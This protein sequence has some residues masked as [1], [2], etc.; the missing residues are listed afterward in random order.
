MAF[1]I[2]KFFTILIVLTMMSSF[3][4]G[5]ADFGVTIE[6]VVPPKKSVINPLRGTI[7]GGDEVVVK[8]RV[9]NF[10]DTPGE[11]FG[12]MKV[13]TGIY[14][15]DTIQTWYPGVDALFSLFSFQRID[16]CNI[17][18][19]N[20][21]TQKI[22]L[23]EK[24]GT[25][26]SA[27]IDF[28][29]IA[30]DVSFVTTNAFGVHAQSFR[31]CWNEGLG[32]TGQSDYSVFPVKLFTGLSLGDDQTC[33]DGIR[34]QDETGTDCGGVCTSKD[35]QQRFCGRADDCRSDLDC[36]QSTYY[37][38][39]SLIPALS[40]STLIGKCARL[41]VQEPEGNGTGIVVTCGDELCDPFQE[42]WKTCPTD[43]EEPVFPPDFCF[44]NETCID[45]EEITKSNSITIESIIRADPD[46]LAESVC[47]STKRD[48]EDDATCTSLFQLQENNFISESDAKAVAKETQ[49]GLERLADRLGTTGVKVGA[50]SAIPLGVAGCI[51]LA[52]SLSATGVFT[53]PVCLQGLGLGAAGGALVGIEAGIIDAVWGGVRERD[54]KKIAFCVSDEEE[55]KDTGITGGIKK[56]FDKTTD[57]FNDLFFDGKDEKFAKGITVF[58]FIVV[59]LLVFR[60]I[61]GGGNKS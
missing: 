55:P 37:C 35:N 39:D 21:Q 12:C 27:L 29:V 23:D 26:D 18:E 50:V 48:C 2:K 11:T 56:F 40:D 33:S 57:L 10:A 30:P 41:D 38:D 49:S 54:L 24:G 14:R 8:L 6:E 16:N 15:R 1:I 52:T 4:L 25:K 17:W 42:N 20:V 13:E 60:F 34:N 3:V 59:V 58:A 45:V 53:L 5:A 43:C 28:R 46:V 31:W 47:E 7:E 44:N 9:Q 22:C 32:K 51:I 19:T 61:A 36:D